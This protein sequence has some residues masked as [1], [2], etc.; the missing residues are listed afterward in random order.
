MEANKT[1]NR[2]CVLFGGISPE[3][4]IS[5]KSA[6]Y[7]LK[8]LRS[9]GIESFGYYLDRNN[10]P[11]GVKEVLKRVNVLRE[12]GIL[13]P[14]SYDDLLKSGAVCSHPPDIGGLFS[15]LL[16][17]RFDVVFPL[18]HGPGGE[19]GTIQGALEFLGIPFV[20]CGTAGSAMAM[21]KVVTKMLCGANGIDVLEWVSFT[22]FEWERD[23]PGVVKRAERIGYPCFVKP[24]RMGSSIGISRADDRDGLISAVQ[25]ALGYDR[26]VLCERATDAR[27]Y[28]VAVIGNECPEASLAAEISL[29]NDFYD[30]PAKYGPEAVDDIIPA[31][32]N[33]DLT[34]ALRETSLRAYGILGLSGMARVDSFIE[35]GRVYVN[36]VNTIPG[37]G[38]NSLFHRMWE[39]TGI[40]PSRLFERLIGYAL[41]LTDSKPFPSK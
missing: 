12:E 11:A 23:G 4:D 28:S 20:G 19:D 35:N 8:S 18:F 5:V 13:Q 38:G 3:H 16:S 14:G 26:K 21:D 34:R 15:I 27:E 39:K 37:L 7:A 29:W 36:E 22:G 41:E 33:P 25:K 6:L 1:R 2:V 30:Y 10:H 40:P 9:A 24:A 17:G 32:L 31:S